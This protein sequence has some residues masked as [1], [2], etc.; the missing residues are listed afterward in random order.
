MGEYYRYVYDKDGNIILDKN[1]QPIVRVAGCVDDSPK[2]SI[3]HYRKRI[4]RERKEAERLKALEKKK[5]A[6]ER[7]RK[8]ELKLAQQGKA[9]LPQ[10]V[11]EPLSPEETEALM[12]Q[13]N[14]RIQFNDAG[15]PITMQNGYSSEDCDFINAQN[16]VYGYHENE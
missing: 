16:G 9:P 10:K 6:E 13:F 15:M 4:E 12:P 1:G 14:S 11:E 2:E 3:W 7:K 8:R 5:K